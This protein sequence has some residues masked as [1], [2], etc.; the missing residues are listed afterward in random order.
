MKEKP[1]AIVITLTGGLVACICCIIRHAGLLKTLTVVLISLIVFM[2]IGIIVN[3][4]YMTIKSEVEERDKELARI[5]EEARLARL[6]EEKSREEEEA[7]ENGE[8]DSQSEEDDWANATP[9]EGE[10]GEEF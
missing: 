5:E 8:E 4:I 10:N 7:S 3:K 1:L 2:I 9:S 6:E